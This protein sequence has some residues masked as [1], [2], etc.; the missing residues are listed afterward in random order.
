MGAAAAPGTPGAPIGSG[1]LSAEV[2]AQY[3]AVWQLGLDGGLNY[4]R[5]S[6]LRPAT[7]QDPGASAISLPPEMLHIPQPTLVL[8]AQGDIA[9]LPGLCEGLEAFVPHM[10]LVPLP[11]ATHWVVHEQPARVITEIA[12]FLK[13]Q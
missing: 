11:Q 8:W 2:R 5:A 6:P 4:Y 10:R 7:E 9:L 3:R 13:A 1:W 12:D